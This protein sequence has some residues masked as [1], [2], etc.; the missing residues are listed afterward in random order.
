VH[1]LLVEDD[2]KFA[3]LLARGLVEEGLTVEPVATGTEALD[4][5]RSGRFDVC[6]LDVMLPD[7][8]GFQVLEQARVARVATPILMLT[9]RDAIPDRVRGLMSGADDYLTKPFAFAELLARL[10]VIARRKVPGASPARLRAGALE[11]DLATRLVTRAGVPVSLSA[12]QFALLEHLVR[13]RGEVVSR[14]IFLRDVFGY[15]FDPGTNIVD[16]HV[17]HLRRRIDGGQPPSLI[18]TVRGVGYRVASDGPL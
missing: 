7:K 3:A 2:P 8:D 14:E 4:R 1:L 11:L 9:A 5:L 17:S 15:K 18:E 13:H 12:S 6:L 16:V 10:H